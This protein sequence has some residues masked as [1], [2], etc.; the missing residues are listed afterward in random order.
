MDAHAAGRL[1][2]A[3]GT[4]E[5]PASVESRRPCA[6]R[7]Y[8][9]AGLLVAIAVMGVLMSAALPVWRTYMQREKEAELV[10]RGQQYMRA[11]DLYQRRFPG[12]YPTD[13]EAL[14]EGRFLRRLYLDPM[15]GGPFRVLTQG[16]AASAVLGEATAAGFGGRTAGDDPDGQAGGGRLSDRLGRGSSGSNGR[17]FGRTSSSTDG[18]L[19]RTSSGSTGQGFGRTS[20]GSTGRGFG[21]ASSSTG[22]GFG[23]TSSSSIG[24]GLGRTSAGGLGRASSGLTGRGLDRR[25]DSAG[26]SRFSRAAGGTD[27]E[28]GG[29]VGVVSRSSEASLREYNGAARYDQWLF[30]HAQSA[31]APGEAGM[32][33]AG[34]GIGVGPEGRARLSSQPTGGRGNGADRNRGRS[35]LRGR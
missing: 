3:A 7:G 14:V 8:A 18:G 23:R 20:S 32:P 5:A 24:R 6:E 33:G 16:S 2:T 19:G 25:S 12:A 35:P 10:F 15:T 26:R 4:D 29:I 9:M 13:L 21:G 31:A 28:L 30:V 22:R 11:I 34:G 27:D 1:L 17:S